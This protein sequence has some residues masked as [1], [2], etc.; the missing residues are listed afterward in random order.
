[1]GL[2]RQF[3]GKAPAYHMP[4]LRFHPQDGSKKFKCL[5]FAFIVL[6]LLTV[7]LLR[8]GTPCGQGIHS[9]AL[10]NQKTVRGESHK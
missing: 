8:P 9:L 3:N 6:K 1:M 10:K 5:I 4:S 2:G 7:I